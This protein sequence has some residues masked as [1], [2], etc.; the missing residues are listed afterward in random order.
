MRNHLCS[1]ALA[2]A[3]FLA[4]GVLTGCSQEA[5]NQ[6]TGA[7]T[8]PATADASSAASKTASVTKT[9]VLDV[10]GMT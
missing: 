1:G 2:V 5:E 6:E 10:T 7:V 8:T 3:A 9:A 4:G